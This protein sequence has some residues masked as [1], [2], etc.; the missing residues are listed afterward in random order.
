MTVNIVIP[1]YA[2][3]FVDAFSHLAGEDEDDTQVY[4]QNIYAILFAFKNDPRGQYL[5]VEDC[6]CKYQKIK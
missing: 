1:D 4:I 5:P 3:V 2:A 6:S